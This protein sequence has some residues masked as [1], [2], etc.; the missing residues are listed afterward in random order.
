MPL[1]PCMSRAA[2]AMSSALP[3]LL[4]FKIETISGVS[5]PWSVRAPEPQ[6]GMQAER[7]LGLHVDEL[8]LDQL[9]GGERAAELAALERVVARGMPAEFGGAERAPS[10]AIPG[11]VETGERAAQPA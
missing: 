2:R 8:F 5:R 9:V 11:T 10:D 4:R 6:A 3:Q 7:D 1:P